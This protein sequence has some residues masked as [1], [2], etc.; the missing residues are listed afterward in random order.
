MNTNAFWATTKMSRNPDNLLCITIDKEAH[1]VDYE[2][3]QG[4]WRI[5]GRLMGWLIVN[6]LRRTVKAR[7][8]GLKSKG[9]KRKRTEWIVEH[10]A[11][12]EHCE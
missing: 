4:H 9:K 10:N 11:L 1:I 12:S 3:E 6:Q 7:I 2:S 8:Q 5:A